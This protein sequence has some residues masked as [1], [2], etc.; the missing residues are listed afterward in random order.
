MKKD[1]IQ[2]RNRKI[3]TKL[4]KASMCRD[5]RFDANF[6]FLEKNPLGAAA[7]YSSGPF[8]QVHHTLSGLPH[9]PH[10]AHQRM[11]HHLA[12][13]SFPGGPHHHM[14]QHPGHPMH[15]PSHQ[16]TASASNSLALGLNHS[17]MVHALG[18]VKVTPGFRAISSVL[19]ADLPRIELTKA[20][21][22]VPFLPKAKVFHIISILRYQSSSE[23]NKPKQFSLHN[24]SSF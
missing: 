24:V 6:N 3:S 8:G 15:H 1:G 10:H 11:S 20:Y 14:L 19:G 5:P 9:H 4:K 13:S 12:G 16:A 22:K 2:T 18:W 7:A 21:C 17:N 23:V